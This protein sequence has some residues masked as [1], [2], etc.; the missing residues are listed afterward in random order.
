MIFNE[1]TQE[2]KIFFTIWGDNLPIPMIFV[3]KMNNYS[4]HTEV[5]GFC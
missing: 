1:K 5:I 2:S 4:N 3:P